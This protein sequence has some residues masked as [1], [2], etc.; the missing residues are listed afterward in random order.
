MTLW[1]CLL[2]NRTVHGLWCMESMLEGLQQSGYWACSRQR[3]FKGHTLWAY[4]RAERLWVFPEGAVE[5]RKSRMQ[6]MRDKRRGPSLLHWP[7]SAICWQCWHYAPC[8]GEMLIEPRPLSQE[9][10]LLGW[11]WSSEAINWSFTCPNID[12]TPVFIN[13]LTDE[14][15]VVNLYNGKHHS[16]IKINEQL[17]HTQL[18]CITKTFCWEKSSQTQ[19]GTYYVTLFI[20]NT[21][22]GKPAVS[23]APARKIHCKGA[24][25]TFWA[26]E[27]V[28]YFD[29]HG[30][31]MDV[32]IFQNS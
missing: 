21:L 4:D 23:G 16:A 19:K 13:R 6:R 29:C 9:K 11:I 20:G 18:R 28:L 27:N 2:T 26:D 15:T 24:C 22:T 8:K 32:Y 5:T 10:V 3:S 30:D 1:G 7:S 12:M 17:T 14:Q 31:Y 25:G